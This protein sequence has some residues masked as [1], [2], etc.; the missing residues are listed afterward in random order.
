M[1]L[2]VVTQYLP[3]MARISRFGRCLKTL[4][5]FAY[6]PGHLSQFVDAEDEHFKKLER[7]TVILYGNQ[8]TEYSQRN[9]KG[10]LLSGESSNG[11]TVT[12]Q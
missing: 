10:P 11:Q 5:T 6:L 2:K 12:H 7:S 3:L 4:E 1:H 8:L 9:K